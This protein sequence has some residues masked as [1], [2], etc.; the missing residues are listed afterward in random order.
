MG[1]DQRIKTLHFSLVDIKPAALAKFVLIFHML[2]RYAT[3]KGMKTQGHEDVLVVVAYLYTCQ[4]I[5]P[6]VLEKLY[7]HLDLLIL[8][9][10]DDQDFA[11]HEVLPFVY[12]PPDTR[13]AILKV[14]KQWRHPVSSHYAVSRIRPI[15]R[16]NVKMTRSRTMAAFGPEDSVSKKDRKDFDA[17]G[18]LFA[19]MDFFQR[20]EP[21]L[22]TLYQACQSSA[23]PPKRKELE[24]YLDAK[25]SVNVTFLDSDH[26]ATMSEDLEDIA[27]YYA[28]GCELWSVHDESV[29]HLGEFDP[30][31]TLEAFMRGAPY[32]VLK[33]MGMFFDGVAVTM[34]SFLEALRVELVLGEM[35][36]FMD[37]VR[38]DALEYRSCAPT[39]DRDVDPR[40]FPKTYDLI[41]LSNIP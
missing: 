28:S 2:I 41:H 10:Q 25:W 35:T 40:T 20:R 11:H 15:I 24:D 5:P 14:F 34:V 1:A 8:L 32:T 21:E 12:I 33:G 17:W 26:E 37:R 38:F 6:F 9:L 29:A 18:C 16:Q 23:S 39:S 30:S 19:D 31:K 7:Q 27:R 36:D 13:R 22:V 3:M 4:V